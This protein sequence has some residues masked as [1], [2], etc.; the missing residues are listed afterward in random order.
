MT[1]N[2]FFELSMIE[3]RVQNRHYLQ[4]AR[5]CDT[6]PPV[7]KTRN[8][9]DDHFSNNRMY[10]TILCENHTADP[11][12]ACNIAG[13]EVLLYCKYRLINRTQLSLYYMSS[14]KMLPSQQRTKAV[15]LWQSFRKTDDG[16]WVKVRRLFLLTVLDQKFASGALQVEVENGRKRSECATVCTVCA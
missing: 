14:G 16:K 8:V 1:L 6:I 7:V 3:R 2:V 5:S 12:S 10:K 15:T 4:L 13:C 11:M 9:G